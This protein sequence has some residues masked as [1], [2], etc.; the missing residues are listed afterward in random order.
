M[1]LLEMKDY[2]ILPTP[3]ALLVRPIR[4][5]YNSDRT[6]QKESFY[7]QMSYLYFMVDPRSPYIDIADEDERKQQICFQ[8][9]L[10]ESF[11]PSK[12]LRE[13]M[14]LY[15]RLTTTTSKRLLEATRVAADALKKELENTDAILAERTDKGARVTKPNDIISVLERLLKVIPQLE[16]L[17]RKVDSEIKENTRARG[18]ENTMFEDG[19]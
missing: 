5:I 14:E 16:D 3:E 10:P 1:K 11:K 7:Q 2:R 6:K 19:V 15:E 9:G 13:A 4:K 18:T 12:D 8:E 17:E